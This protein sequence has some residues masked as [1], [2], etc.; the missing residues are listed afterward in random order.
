MTLTENW[1]ELKN[2]V[3]KNLL[4]IWVSKLFYSEKIWWVDFY[5][6]FS[7]VNKNFDLQKFEKLL[8]E[9]IDLLINTKTTKFRAENIKDLS[10]GDI[11]KIIGSSL[12]Q[13]DDS[14]SLWFDIQTLMDSEMFNIKRDFS[15]I[16]NDEYQDK[17]RIWISRYLSWLYSISEQDMEID[18]P[19]IIQRNSII[20]SER[21]INILEIMN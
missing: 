4:K 12:D 15:I 6:E 14:F 18:T 2:E 16:D 19:E 1:V 10:E 7:D 8:N 13:L 9:I 21:I 17:V 5:W 11:K 20:I 3:T